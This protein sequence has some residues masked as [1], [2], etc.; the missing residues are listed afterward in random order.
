MA[1]HKPRDLSPYQQG[2][3]NSS[4]QEAEMDTSHGD[5]RILQRDCRKVKSL[6]AG[7][8]SRPGGKQRIERRNDDEL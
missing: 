7:S 2:D 8:P 3:K 4:Q 5:V 1:A 6:P